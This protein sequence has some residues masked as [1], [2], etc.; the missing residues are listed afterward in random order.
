MFMM[1]TCQGDIANGTVGEI[2]EETKNEYGST[3]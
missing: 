3:M 2:E 1:G